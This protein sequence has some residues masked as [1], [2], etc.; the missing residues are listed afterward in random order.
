MSKETLKAVG[1]RLKRVSDALGISQK[2]FARSIG[3]TPSNFSHLVNGR[4]KDPGIL[5]FLEI[6]KQYHVS[7]EYLLNGSGDMFLIR[8]QPGEGQERDQVEEIE[9]V[10]DLLWFFERSK[11]FRDSIMGYAGKFKYEN[12]VIIKKSIDKYKAKLKEK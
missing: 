9:N 8:A 5:V 1:E 2:D 11:F 6:A 3:L 12:E 4:T 10:D 7:L